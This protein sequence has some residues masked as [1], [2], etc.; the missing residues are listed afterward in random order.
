MAGWLPIHSSEGGSPTVGHG[1]GDHCW[2]RMGLG[3]RRLSEETGAPPC[4]RGCIQQDPTGPGLL[5]LILPSM[6]GS[7]PPDR[8]A[9]CPPRRW[10]AANARS[11]VWAGPWRPC[12]FSVSLEV[13]E[14]P[15]CLGL[16]RF[17]QMST[18]RAWG[19]QPA[20][21]PDDYCTQGDAALT[22]FQARR[23]K[24]HQAGPGF[25]PLTS[26]CKDG[27]VHH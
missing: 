21:P 4:S 9:A 23:L 6:L 1:H 13:E 11:Q 16:G 24:C 5:G 27:P 7:P 20:S 8:P 22:E 2:G 12:A 14:R 15:G 19:A 18:A 25:T 26:P 3:R 17:A 10:G